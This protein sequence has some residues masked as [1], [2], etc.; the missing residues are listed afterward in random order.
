ML[1]VIW[2]SLQ[3]TSRLMNLAINGIL[4]TV[5]GVAAEVLWRN[6]YTP[7]PIDTDTVTLL[8]LQHHL[9]LIPGAVGIIIIV[10]LLVTSALSVKARRKVNSVIERYFGKIWLELIMVGIIG[11]IYYLIY[12]YT[13]ELFNYRGSIWYFAFN[14]FLD[15]NIWQKIMGVGPGLLDTVTQA[16]IAKA[17]FYVEWNWFYCTAHN[18]LLEYLVT[19]GI[20]GTV[21][22]LLMYILPYIMYARG[23]SR[24]SEKAAVLAALTGFIGQG[25]MTGPY[26]L[27]YA[28]YTIFLGV[29]AAY[30]RM[31]K[32][33]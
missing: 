10:F 22:K 25:L 17:D 2:Y 19:T 24:K 31:D 20:V 4:F 11:V 5:A 33:Q 9:Y 30:D 15:G 12:N 29:M 21:L 6:P 32:A 13:L 28:F 3:K 16:Q 8:L 18:D 1:F 27:T 14:G 26:I 23:K 7:R